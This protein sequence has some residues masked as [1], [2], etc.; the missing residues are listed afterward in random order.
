MAETELERRR[1]AT[2]LDDGAPPVSAFIRYGT[3]NTIGIVRGRR[4]RLSVDLG[5][6]AGKNHARSHGTA[7]GAGRTGE[8]RKKL[9]AQVKARPN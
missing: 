1:A 6:N 8:F 2:N 4:S 7:S 5:R 9:G 3:A